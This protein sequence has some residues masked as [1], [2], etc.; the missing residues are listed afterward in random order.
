MKEFFGPIPVPAVI[1]AVAAALL[2]TL[3]SC[4]PHRWVEL[5]ERAWRK[6]RNR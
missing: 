3:I 2:V 1:A 4:A 6:R 5:A